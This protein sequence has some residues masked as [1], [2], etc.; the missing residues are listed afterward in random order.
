MAKLL[1]SSRLNVERCGKKEGLRLS[2]GA[3]SM[4]QQAQA[5][6][7]KVEEEEGSHVK[8]KLANNILLRFQRRNVAQLIDSFFRFFQRYRKL[9]KKREDQ[10]REGG[11]FVS[12]VEP[13]A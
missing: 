8:N 5:S 1:K 2:E 12:L 3:R 10:L 9:A 4:R 11:F 13:F 6:R 7:L